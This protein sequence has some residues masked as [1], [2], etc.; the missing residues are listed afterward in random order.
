VSH[1]RTTATVT[2]ASGVIRSLRPLPWHGDVRPGAEVD[3]AAGQPGQ[4]GDPQPGLRGERE[5]G[6]V[7]PPGPGGL[8]RCGEEGIGFGFGEPGDEGPV[9]LLR[10]DREDAGDRFGVLG[11]P[12]GCVGEHGADRGEAGVA[13]AGAV[14]AVLLEVVQEAADQRR[15]EVGDVKLAWLFSGALGG[16]GQEQPPGVAVGGDGLPAGVPLA[17]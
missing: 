11:M 16:E 12:E 17:G 14:A 3:V 2:V 13:G 5:H 15:V 6:M 1:A 9:E 10:G 7:A 4:L 8:V